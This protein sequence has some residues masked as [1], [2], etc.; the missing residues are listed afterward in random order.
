MI[1]AATPARGAREVL[2]SFRGAG[3]HNLERLKTLWSKRSGQAL[4]A[5][6]AR[7]FSR[8]STW[9]TDWRYRPGEVRAA[10]AKEFL[11]SVGE[12]ISWAGG[13]M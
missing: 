9:S 10:E 6:L 7:H 12:I 13:R 8:V 2:A 5:R 1:L 3:A 4:P 11:D